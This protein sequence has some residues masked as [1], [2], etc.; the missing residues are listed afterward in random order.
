M[1]DWS[2]QDYL[3]FEDERLRP[4]HE[5]ANAGPLKVVITIVVL[6]CGPGT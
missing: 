1:Q 3:K 6:G 2:A 5:L 4:V